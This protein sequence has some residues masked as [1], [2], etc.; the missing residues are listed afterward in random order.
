MENMNTTVITVLA[1]AMAIFIYKGIN[2][3]PQQHAWVVE[4]LG[5]YFETLTPGLHFV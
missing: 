4:R 2:I 3:V 1:I 5:K